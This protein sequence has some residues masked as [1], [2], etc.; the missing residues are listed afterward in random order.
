MSRSFHRLPGARSIASAA[1]LLCSFLCQNALAQT[2]PEREIR[3]VVPFAPGGANDAIARIYAAGMGSR[4][5]KNIVVDNRPGAGGVIGANHVASTPPDGYTLLLGANAVLVVNPLIYPKLDYRPDSFSAVAIA[6]EIPLVLTVN[7][8]VPAS[9]LNELVAYI[10]RSPG[11]INYAS[12]G[13]GT[14][15]HLLGELFKTQADLDITHVAYKGSAPAMS[16]LVGGQVHMMFDT[17]NSALP[18][19]R[20]GKVR[21]ITVNSGKRLE[22]LPDVPTVVEAGMPAIGAPTW[23]S[24]MT[25]AGTPKPVLDRLRQVAGETIKDPKTRQRLQALGAQP[26]EAMPDDA[27]NYIETERTRW[28]R[29]VQQAKIKVD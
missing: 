21:A 28:T 5:G 12:P 1:L 18:H 11:K 4:L 25:P 29:I 23:F 24:I 14:Q 22:S 27:A 6:A 9:T 26:P 7:A 17:V 3:L 13:V 15:M 20:S 10:K 19:I 16:D 8:A 2:Y